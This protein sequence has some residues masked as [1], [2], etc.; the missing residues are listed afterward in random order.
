MPWVDG[1]TIGEALRRSAERR[2]DDDAVVF[3]DIG[4]R[5]TFSEFDRMVDEAALGLLALGLNKGDHLALW[6]TNRPQWVILQFATA[7]V[8]VVLVTVN[9]A[10]RASELEYVLRQSDARALALIDT[11]KTSNYYDIFEEV[12]PELSRSEP[13]T[14]RC[15]KFPELRWVVALAD[16]PRTGML[17]WSELLRRGGGVGKNQLTQREA[18]LSP[19]DP[20]NIQYTSGTTGFPKGA[21]LSHR[22]LLLNGYYVGASQ[23]LGPRDRVCIPV[24]FYHCFG[25]VLGTICTVVH[26]AAMVIPHE[27]FDACKTLDAVERERCTALYGVPTMF[28]AQMEHP[29]Y[30]G[31]DLTSLRTGIMAGSPC[32]IELM[33]KV[34]T[35][36]GARELTIAYGQTEASPVITQTRADDP[37]ELRVETVGRP[38]P[39]VEVKIVDPATGTTMNVDE[40]GELCAR[41]H[42]VML[43]YYNMPQQTAAAIDADG[44]LHT[45]DLGVRL[46]NGYFRITGRIKDMIIRGGEKI[47]PREVEEYLYKHPKIQDVQVVGVPD[48]KYGEQVLAWIRLRDGQS[49]T[50]EEVRDHCRAGMAHY[51]VPRYI[52]FVTA[53]PMT[54]T[55]KVQKYMIRQKAIEELGLEAA[56]RARTA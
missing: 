33:K 35:Q 55:G 54:V 19:T 11:F 51:K 23:R 15:A 12:C 1:Q 7:R 8:G 53:F 31:R 21:M 56:A 10:N 20:I 42:V 37:I 49:A 4:L 43:G 16:K 2:P 38:L 17:A 26:G 46:G 24:P 36:M 25:C 48:E 40:P 32:P 13:G 44:W 28:I 22:N 30:A 41:G 45:G 6:C 47:Y 39:G 52:K 27:Y 14:L 18:T 29:S 3:P 34:T 50:E 5:A 9:P